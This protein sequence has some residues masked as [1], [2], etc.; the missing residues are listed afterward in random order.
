MMNEILT[1][2]APAYFY[3]GTGRLRPSKWVT[4]ALILFLALVPL[5]Y[6]ITDSTWIVKLFIS[7]NIFALFAIS[8]D[9][10][11]GYTGQE[12]FGHHF[13]VGVGGFMV[14]LFTVAL[15]KGATIE[16][17]QYS[18]LIGFQLPAVVIIPAG[19]IISAVFGLLIG[20]PCLRL[21][22]LFLA[23]ATLAMGLIFVEFTDNILPILHP[24][25]TTYC[26][27]GVYNIAHLTGGNITSFYY[28]TLSVM[29]VSLFM[30]YTYT[31]SHY[32]LLLKA[33]REDETATKAV[34]INTTYYKV[35]IFAVSAFFAGIGGTFYAYSLGAITGMY[36]DTHLLLKIVSIC[37]VGG[38]GTI[39]GSF[40]GAYFLM[41]VLMGMDEI[42]R[43]ISDVT[44]I[45]GI[46]AAYRIFED[47]FYYGVIVIVML[48]MPEGVITT[49]IK[50]CTSRYNQMKAYHE[51]EN[52]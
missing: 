17:V 21:S 40:G 38:M 14:G 46:R 50:K 26:T 35:A 52:Q 11:S 9:F 29:V 42:A 1:S 28:I 18:P 10:L 19:G 43:L 39:T 13:F 34:G 45:M 16:G 27:E 48:F 23:L 15:V 41:F 5:H 6:F 12:N 30:I 31:R 8:W 44:D 4:L 37:I 25:L 51:D 7:A 22:G 32:G 33:I 2:A 47:I 20:I 49:F 36:I 24:V 3:P